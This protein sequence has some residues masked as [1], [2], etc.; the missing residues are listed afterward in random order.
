MCGKSGIAANVGRVLIVFN[1]LSE[2]LV[3]TE[4]FKN[5]NYLGDPLINIAIASRFLPSEIILLDIS[6]RFQRSPCGSAYL[7][8]LPIHCE[9]PLG[10]G[11]SLTTEKAT[12]LLKRGFDKII[13]GNKSQKETD[14]TVLAK[15]FGSQAVSFCIDYAKSERKD[16]VLLNDKELH[17]SEAINYIFEVQKSGFG[18][19]IF[20]DKVADGTR[21]G[22]RPDC[23][24]ITAVKETGIPITWIGGV[25]DKNNVLENFRDHQLD[26]IGVGAAYSYLDGTKQLLPHWNF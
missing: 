15:R 16:H 21:I 1:L 20:N 17:L 19:F 13:V 9:V 18:E 26:A 7:E 2:T 4:K 3:K 12:R 25:K 14:I 6:S 22:L 8:T 24:L 23:Q 5:P 10:V 11:G